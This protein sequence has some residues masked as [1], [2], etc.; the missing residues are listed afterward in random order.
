M[1]SK[2]S[3]A[4]CSPFLPR[5]SLDTAKH[6]TKSPQQLA[7]AH[8]TRALWLYRC[9][10]TERLTMTV[11]RAILSKSPMKCILLQPS[12]VLLS[13]GHFSANNLNINMLH[14]TSKSRLWKW[15]MWKLSRFLKS[16]VT[17][18]TL[19]SCLQSLH[20]SKIC[21][22]TCFKQDTISTNRNERS[23]TYDE[24]LQQLSVPLKVISRMLY[25]QSKPNW[26]AS[27]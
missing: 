25:Q 26:I 13:E 16:K 14:Q 19:I 8:F 4:A 20:L 21:K 12:P 5:K 2:L 22:K 18:S 7:L 17:T 15:R 11:T 6:T 3:P 9:L 24:I 23:Q 27:T 1:Q 10:A